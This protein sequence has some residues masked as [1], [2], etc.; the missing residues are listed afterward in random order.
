MLQ[1]PNSFR[2]KEYVKKGVPVIFSGGAEDWECT[3]KWNL[4]Y[5]DE[6]FG[7]VSFP[8]VARKGLLSKDE[9]IPDGFEKEFTK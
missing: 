3:K 6:K 9:K 5:L 7:D 1:K 2:P 8:I 4:D